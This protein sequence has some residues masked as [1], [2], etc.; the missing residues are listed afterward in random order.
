MKKILIAPNSFK[1]SA[2]SVEVTHLFQKY[3]NSTVYE[4][5]SKPISDGGDGFL[6]VCSDNYDLELIDFTIPSPYMPKRNSN[7]S[8]GYSFKLKTIFI[9][10]A[11]VL[12]LKKIPNKKRHP[13]ILNSSGLGELLNKIKLR[14]NKKS[15]NKIVIGIGGTGT[16]DMGIG[17]LSSLGLK[18]IDKYGK[19]LAPIPKNF[20]NTVKIEYPVDIF[21]YDIDMIID[22]NNPLL[23]ENGGIQI[24]GGQKGASENDINIIEDGME[25][26]LKILK[27]DKMIKDKF[28]LSGSGGGIPAGLSLFLKTK[29]KSS[30]DFILNDLNLIEYRNI[31]YLITGEGKFDSQSFYN[32]GT[33]ILLNQFKNIEKI[34]LCCGIIDKSYNFPS[35]VYPIQF[36]DFFKNYE[37]SLTNIGKG[38]ELVCSKIQQII[39]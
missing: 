30:K 9:E 7:V 36:V 23:G 26:I 38:I 14:F 29:S 34:F 22:V 5:I 25:N 37:E 3:L 39:S 1:E 20:I 33:G 21:P 6:S 2:S 24:F 10:S 28:F 27:K 11:E 31:N 12:G 15:L 16:I 4:I 8:V 17:A 13:L 18:L 32:K 35:N 19:G